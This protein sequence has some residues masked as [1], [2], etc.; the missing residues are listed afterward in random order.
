MLLE[1][2]KVFTASFGCFVSAY[3]IVNM[4]NKSI[5]YS[6]DYVGISN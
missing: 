5:Y 3:K 2:F 4:N 1:L 6:T